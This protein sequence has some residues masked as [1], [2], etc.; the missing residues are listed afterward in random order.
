M[1]IEYYTS[2]IF[3]LCMESKK[4]NRSLGRQSR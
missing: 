1:D 2:E 3:A 4:A